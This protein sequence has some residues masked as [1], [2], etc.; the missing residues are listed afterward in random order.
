MA[1]R[2]SF[3]KAIA[4][5]ESS[6]TD[7]AIALLWYYR[8]TQEFEER[9]LTLSG[10][11]ADEAKKRDQAC[12]APVAKGARTGHEVVVRQRLGN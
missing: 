11:T 8:Q 5:F 4:S 12:D 7:R 10:A 2:S 1:D 9:A 6:H 3:S